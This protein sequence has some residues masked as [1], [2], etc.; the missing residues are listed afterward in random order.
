MYCL[1]K[2]SVCICQD[3]YNCFYM[4]GLVQD[5]GISNAL[6]IEMLQFC[7]KPSISFQHYQFCTTSHLHSITKHLDLMIVCIGDPITIS[8]L[9]RICHLI[10]CCNVN[11]GPDIKPIYNPIYDAINL[12]RFYCLAIICWNPMRLMKTGTII[13]GPLKRY[14]FNFIHIICLPSA[15]RPMGCSSKSYI[16]HPATKLWPVPW[17]HQC[18]CHAKQTDNDFA[19]SVRKC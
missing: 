5:C 7:I 17:Q 14:Y 15:H 10:N 18:A 3:L 12:C 4:D 16:W 19:V 13:K 1:R 2:S 11:N 8:T 6:A 9:N